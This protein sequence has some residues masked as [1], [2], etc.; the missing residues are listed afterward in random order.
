M[1]YTFNLTEGWNWFSFPLQLEETTSDCHPYASYDS[2]VDVD[3][4]C[5]LP[6]DLFTHGDIIKTTT[7]VSHVYDG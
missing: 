7:V 3:I 4:N 2:N 1:I 5:I 6:L